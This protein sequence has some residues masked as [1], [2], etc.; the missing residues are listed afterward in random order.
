MAPA[1]AVRAAR[2]RCD[3]ATAR[4]LALDA[5]PDGDPDLLVELGRLQIELG[6]YAEALETCTRAVETAPAALRPR[7]QAGLISALRGLGR[8]D[9]GEQVASAA[10]LEA[11][12]SAV[13]RIEAGGLAVDASRL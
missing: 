10:V 3:Y 4:A 1:E 2:A 5:A 6:Q 11:P 9:D 7:A 8:Y 13:I 12:D